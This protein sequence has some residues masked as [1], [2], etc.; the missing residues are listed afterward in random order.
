MNL[1]I[2]LAMAIAPGLAIAIFIYWKDKYDKEPR[3]LMIISFILGM[4]SVIPAILLEDIGS[5]WIPPLSETM[6]TFFF[7][8]VVVGGS[9]EFSKFFMLR[10]YPYRKRE[11]NEP[12]DGIT[13]AVMVSMGFA[14]LENIMYVTQYG[15][16]NALLRMF[17][18]V[19]AHAAFGVIMGYYIGLAK[20]KNN[21]I[22][23]QLQG[24]LFAVTLHGAYDFCLMANNIPL[25]AGG[26]LVSLVLGIRYSLKAIRLHQQIS[27]FNINAHNMHDA[28]SNRR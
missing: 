8:F 14:T 23:L 25:I 27:P 4:L 9:E 10:V 11:F 20:F 19:P 1:L 5:S 15:M 18:A 16:G 22:L 13:Y 21:S 28:R 26:A 2:L 12:F 7:T 3:K 6:R 24:L 17:T